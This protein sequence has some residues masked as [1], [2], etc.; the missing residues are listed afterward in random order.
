MLK[1]K[2]LKHLRENK[3]NLK[4]LEAVVGRGGLLWPVSSG[5][6]AVNERMKQDLHDNVQGI[7]ASNLGGLIAAEI[8]AQFDVPAY[9]VDP[10]VVDEVRDE[11][12]ITGMRDI[13]RKIISHAL[14]QI[15]TAKRFAED[16]GR[17]Y[18]EINVIVAHM[19]GGI[20]IGAHY[21]GRYV[22]VNNAL[23]GEGPFTPERSGSL[24][25]GQ[26]IQLCYS[27]KY[28]LKEM[29]LKNV[30]RGGLYDLLGTTDFL[31]IEKKVLAGDKK[32]T[33][34]FN[35]MAYQVARWIS[36]LLP[37]FESEPVDQ[38]LLTG[39]LARC[40]PFVE[41]IKNRVA[42][43]GVGVTVYPGENEMAALRKGALRVL[44]KKEEVKEYTGKHQGDNEDF[45]Q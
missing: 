2:I 22:E 12:K 31:Q 29:K 20:S 40:Q 10:V 37:A 23:D 41:A 36:S 4:K 38:I 6:Y 25:V 8:A 44:M 17:F 3:I 33:H 34:V 42:A 5:T 26:L 16:R 15:A 1:N 28:M 21:K 13:R 32:T 45:N 9:I 30:G 11:Y 19:G 27:R 24:P 35:A 18:K 14:S 7:H 39:G 43:L